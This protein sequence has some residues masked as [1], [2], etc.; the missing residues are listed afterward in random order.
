MCIPVL[1][2]YGSYK[3]MADHGFFD[4]FPILNHQNFL[5]PNLMLFSPLLK[6]LDVSTKIGL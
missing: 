5:R 3:V 2:P 6:S 4:N 1:G